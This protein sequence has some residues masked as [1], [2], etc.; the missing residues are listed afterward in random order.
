MLLFLRQ[1]SKV[2]WEADRVAEHERV[3]VV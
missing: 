2:Y 3:H 1:L